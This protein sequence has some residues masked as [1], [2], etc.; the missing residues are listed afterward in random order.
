MD[1]LI[2]RL[3]AG[4][5]WDG[6]NA[7][8]LR[9][10]GLQVSDT[11]TLIIMDEGTALYQECYPFDSVDDALALVPEGWSIHINQ[12]DDRRFYAE[13][14]EGYCTSYN[15]VA[16]GSSPILCEALTIAILEASRG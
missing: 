2:K 12:Q 1:D 5:R 14:R 13:L 11:G 8:V 3:S 15:R 6:D 7:E 9:A 10:M 16:I 4:E